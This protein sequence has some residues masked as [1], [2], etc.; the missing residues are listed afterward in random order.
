MIRMNGC[1]NEE[2]VSAIGGHVCA[3]DPLDL[4]EILL[5][6]VALLSMTHAG[7]QHCY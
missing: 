6:D 5:R 2:S 4:K 3:S 7:K 1:L